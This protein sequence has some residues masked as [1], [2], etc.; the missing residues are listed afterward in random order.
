MIPASVYSKQNHLLSKSFLYLHLCLV[1]L[2]IVFIIYYEES[3]KY[4]GCI[5]NE[6]MDCKQ[7]VG[8]RGWTRCTE[9]LAMEA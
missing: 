2:C 1:L 8:L 6:H 3:Y 7:M 9:C 5:V 4:F